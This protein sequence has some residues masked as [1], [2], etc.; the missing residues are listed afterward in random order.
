MCLE[1]TCTWQAHLLT[2][3]DTRWHPP[4]ALCAFSQVCRQPLLFARTVAAL[5]LSLKRAPSTS[6]S[7][8]LSQPQSQ[9]QFSQGSMSQGGPGGGLGDTAQRRSLLA[10][11]RPALTAALRATDGAAQGGAAGCLDL[12]ALYAGYLIGLG[13]TQAAGQHLRGYAKKGS[14]PAVLQLY[15]HFLCATCVAAARPRGGAQARRRV[16]A[17]ARRWVLKAAEAPAGGLGSTGGSGSREAAAAAVLLYQLGYLPRYPFSPP[18]YLM[19]CRHVWCPLTSRPPNNPT[20]RRRCA[21]GPPGSIFPPI[22]RHPNPLCARPRS[23]LLAVVCDAVEASPVDGGWTGFQR[24]Y[25]GGA[26][27]ADAARP[28]DTYDE[29]RWMLW[30]TLACLLGPLPGPVPDK[31]SACPPGKQA[32]WRMSTSHPRYADPLALKG[33]RLGGLGLVC[34]SQCRRGAGGG[35]GTAPSPGLESV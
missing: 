9:S 15:V 31:V 16:L 20:C 17:A 34:A 4:T 24:T 13:S 35:R 7:Q 8:P 3:I 26:A 19:R 11:L 32:T 33:P 29:Q 6:S 25:R 22:S 27:A 21:F 18:G 1:A 10:D 28:A 14:E 23:A 5:Q 2:P 30:R 12:V